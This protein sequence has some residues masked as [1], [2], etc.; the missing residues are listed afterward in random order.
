MLVLEKVL[1]VLVAVMVLLVFTNVLTRYVF[2][3]SIAW[4]EEIARFLFIVVVAVGAVIAMA[5]DEHLSVEF[6][7]Y[8]NSPILNR[9]LKII[10]LIFV[11]LALGIIVFGGTQLV[12]LGMA[13]PA[14]VTGIPLGF[15]Y[16]VV[17]VSMASMLAIVIFK[18]LYLLK[19]EK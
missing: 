1:A 17:V 7:S 5:R 3:V 6:F 15:V 19:G 12:R 14:P 10:S 16:L 13:H 18:L 8:F 11:A 9:V 2:H 4:S